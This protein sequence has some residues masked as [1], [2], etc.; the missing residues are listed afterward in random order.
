MRVP[1]DHTAHR[2][3]DRLGPKLGTWLWSGV[4]P[5]QGDGAWMYGLEV[6]MTGPSVHL[7]DDQDRAGR[8]RE[9]ATPAFGALRR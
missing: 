1:V 5:T 3:P 4:A 9:G 2:R 8:T 7:S 6:V